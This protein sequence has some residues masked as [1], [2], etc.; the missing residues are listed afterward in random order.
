[1]D[2]GKRPAYPDRSI[3]PA[4]RSVQAN[5][6]LMLLM[7]LSEEELISANLELH[8]LFRAQIYFFHQLLLEASV[9]FF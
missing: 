2:T 9:C 6:G 8:C 5:V 3:P 1:M 4:S 7:G